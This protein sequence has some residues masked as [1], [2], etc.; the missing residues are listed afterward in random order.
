MIE[1]MLQSESFL[2]VGVV[3]GLAGTVLL[4][5]RDTAH[6]ALVERPT[7]VVEEAGSELRPAA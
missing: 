4:I 5:V 2:M 7:L 3:V 6:R 1:A